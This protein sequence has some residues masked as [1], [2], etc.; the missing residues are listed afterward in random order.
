MRRIKIAQIGTSQNGHGPLIWQSLIK[1]TDIFEVVGYALPENEREK[2]P[3]QM[4]NFDG[5]REMRS[6]FANTRKW[7]P[8]R[9]STCTWKSRAAPFLRSLKK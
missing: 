1:Q 2:F 6:I 3:A 9:A 5:Y 7:R 4:K 8:R